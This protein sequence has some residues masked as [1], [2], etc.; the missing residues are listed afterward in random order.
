MPPVHG[1]L[2]LP[3]FQLQLLLKQLTGIAR[4]LVI[5]HGL[6]KRA[7]GAGLRGRAAA[8]GPAQ[9]IR[10]RGCLLGG[11]RGLYVRAFGAAQRQI[12]L[13]CHA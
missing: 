7:G 6:G 1:L 4:L 8:Q 11:R 2:G 3:A 12:V 13:L 5:R 10:R 9:Q